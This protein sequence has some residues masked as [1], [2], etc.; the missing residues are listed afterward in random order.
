VAKLKASHQRALRVT[1]RVTLMGALAGCSGGGKSA[2]PGP[3]AK[4]SA[5][6][7]AAPA[8]DPTSEAD[9]RSALA[10]AYPQGDANWFSDDNPTPRTATPVSDAALASCCQRHSALLSTPDYRKLGCC[11]AATWDAGHCTPWG[12]PMPPAMPAWA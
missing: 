12:P 1:W 5:P 8:G 2:G 3:A 6:A 11:S 4:P 9:C 7:V 10:A